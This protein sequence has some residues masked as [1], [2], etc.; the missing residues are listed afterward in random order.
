M[1][2]KQ[3][4]ALAIAATLAAT[5]AQAFDAE[6]FTVSGYVKNETAAL[7][8]DGTF[9]GQASS[10]SDT[11]KYNDSGDLIKSES[12]VKLF[13]N[14]DVGESSS[15]HAELQL[16]NDSKAKGSHYSGNDDYSQ[17]EFLRELY[18]DTTAGEWDLRLGKQQ[19]VWGTADGAK[20]M[21]MINPTDYREM[22][23][24][25]MA[26]SRIP[27]WSAKA[28]RYNDDGSNI[29]IALS[30][31]KE[32]SF[33][34]LNDNLSA[35]VRSN[36]D[37]ATGTYTS[38]TWSDM[39]GTGASANFSNWNADTSS[40]GH[41]QGNPFVL[42]GVDSITGK[43]NG[44]LNIVPDLGSVAALFGRAFEL[45]AAAGGA[46][47]NN[48][49]GLSAT[50]LN[51]ITA[52]FTVGGFNSFDSSGGAT[53]ATLASFSTAFNTNSAAA[54]QNGGAGYTFADINLGTTL[55]WLDD[56]STNTN[57]IGAGNGAGANYTGGATLAAFA[58]KFDTNLDNKS[59]TSAVD[60]V[61]EYMDRTSFATFD[62][63]VNAKSE[64][65]YDMPDD[66]DS[67]LSLKFANTLP[68]GMNYSLA[69]TYQYDP[70][71]VINLSWRDSSGNEVTTSRGAG[72]YTV[73]S[74]SDGTADSVY[75]SVLTI[76]GIGGLAQ[77]ADATDYATLRFTQ[78]LER[79]HNIGAAFDY[80]FDTESIGPV[81][82]RGEG[83]YQKDIYSPVIDRGAMSIGDISKALTMRAGDKFKYVIGADVTALTDMMVSAQFI[84]ERNLDFIDNNVDWDGS[85]CST[86]KT[87]TAENCGV[88]TADFAAMHMS[89]GFKKGIE[90]K[91]FYS[92]FLS[93][94]FGA[95]GEGRWNNIL[96]LEEGGGR[97]NRFDVEY[98]LT[99]DLIGTVEYNKYWGDDNSQFGQLEAASNVQIG[100]KYLFE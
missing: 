28:T 71:P 51:G 21:D 88:Y 49:S 100:L 65:V 48:N 69:Y 68:N 31:P 24:N 74:D 98:S 16:H 36:T 52:G 63:F 5:N 9:N 60:S 56:D 12:T 82:I 33:A 22:A 18:F 75:T 79:A 41:D 62:A 39:T 59:G 6:S 8:K 92:L 99:N 64:Y 57:G 32:N 27:V 45:T 73:D 87:L 25:V 4:L 84:Q 86:T 55:F 1:F 83:V 20:F 19:I 23:Q 94:P 10:T 46:T 44:F 11:T 30:Q 72:F 76:S 34:G 77:V 47:P 61:F 67:N 35:G 42:K 81:V 14:G 85:T 43:Y 93:K 80:A 66:L 96:M 53:D 89:N 40:T 37:L 7:T 58:G 97:W 90:N 29:T 54:G 3:H 38:T 91:E 26:E 95:S 70:N 78:S 17:S 13:V 2:K 50:K 15:M